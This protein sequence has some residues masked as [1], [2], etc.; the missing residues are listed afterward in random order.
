MIKLTFDLC[1]R[2]Q[3]CWKGAFAYFVFGVGRIT[4]YIGW[5]S[6]TG[7]NLYNKIQ[8]AVVGQ[9]PEERLDYL[10]NNYQ[11]WFDRYFDYDDVL[12]H[13]EHMLVTNQAA[14][15]AAREYDTSE[16]L[17]RGKFDENGGWGKEPKM[18]YLEDYED[19]NE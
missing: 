13:L 15:E 10:K 19:I 18:V 6:Q 1:W 12:R 8:A 3:E 2:V 17:C 7:P 16:E 5:D 11:E 4:D 14:E 9:T